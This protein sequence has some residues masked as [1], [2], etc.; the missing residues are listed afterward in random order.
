[1]IIMIMKRPHLDPRPACCA[2]DGSQGAAEVRARSCTLGPVIVV[3]LPSASEQG[4]ETRDPRV[5][6]RNGYLM[7]TS[8]RAHLRGKP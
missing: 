4:V 7:Q 5:V 3:R 8:A 2:M 1:M 6:A